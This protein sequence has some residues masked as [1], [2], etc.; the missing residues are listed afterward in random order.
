[1]VQKGPLLL[2]DALGHLHNGLL[3]LVDAADSQAAE[4]SFSVTYFLVSED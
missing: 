4:L 3:A 1:M 2:D